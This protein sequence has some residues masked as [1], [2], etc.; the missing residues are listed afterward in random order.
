MNLSCAQTRALGEGYAAEALEA[1]ERRAVRE[2]L[3]Q[4]RG[5]R[6]DAALTDP[7]LLFARVPAHVASSE[8]IEHVLAGVRA[9]IAWK[10]A[11]RR[12]ARRPARTWASVAAVAALLLLLPGQRSG[13]APAAMPSALEKASG[14]VAAGVSA[15][16]PASAVPEASPKTSLPP[17]ATIY[18]W[19]SESDQPRVVWIVDRSLDI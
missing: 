1:E 15:L 8:D 16:S 19:S 12:F 7:G 5:C 10:Q 9:G 3:G 4:C 13:R 2:H 17:N 6:E 18:D 11:E 14:G